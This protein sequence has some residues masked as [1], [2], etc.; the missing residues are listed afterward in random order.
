[1]ESSTVCFNASNRF[2]FQL[3][4]KNEELKTSPF[5]R[6]LKNNHMTSKRQEK[7]ENKRET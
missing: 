2:I 3:P 5:C 1:M 6:I 4:T 7:V